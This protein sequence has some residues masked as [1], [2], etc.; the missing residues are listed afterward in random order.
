MLTTVSNSDFK[1]SRI[2]QGMMRLNNWGMNIDELEN[3]ILETIDL[4]VTSFDHA[5]IY[6]GNHL[7][8]SIFGEVLKKNKYIRNKI[9]IITKC[10]IRYNHNSNALVRKYYDTSKEYII[11]TVEKSLKSLNTDYID[12]FLIH[13][14][15][16]LM[17]PDEIAEAFYELHKSGK[18]LY[19]GVSNF[20]P[21]QFKTLQSRL[22]IKL[23]TNQIEISPYS[24]EHFYNENVYFLMEEQI[25]P[26]AWSP[27]AG[28]KLLNPD[29]DKSERINKALKMVAKDINIDELD[30][31]I[32]SWLLSHPLGI[33]P[34]SGSGKINRLKN[35]VKALDVKLNKEQWYAIYT[36]S[37]GY[38]VP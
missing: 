10:D 31:I 37:L 35:A 30:I 28:G 6:G 12:L 25:N 1:M 29:D 16:L 36:A 5:D 27:L 33:F 13:R 4:G 23:I 8:E 24:L 26:M 17:N 18:V 7:C 2:V 3:F 14:P 21:Q 15:D 38:N 9:Q 20:T 19:F 22:N 32:F 11:N 34:I